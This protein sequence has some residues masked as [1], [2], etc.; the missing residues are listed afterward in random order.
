MLLG[1]LQLGVDD[2]LQGAL[3][4]E[5][6]YCG[7]HVGDGAVAAGAAQAH[8]LS[9]A[10]GRSVRGDASVAL[11]VHRLLCGEDRLDA[12]LAGLLG[13]SFRE[14]VLGAELVAHLGDECIVGHTGDVRDLYLGGIA[15]TTS[16]TAADYWYLALLA[17]V[18]KVGLLAD[19]I[20]GIDNDIEAV[21]KDFLVAAFTVEGLEIVDLAMWVDGFDALL[22][23][24][25]LLV[26]DIAVHRVELAVDIGHA[27]FI[28][29][30]HRDVAHAGAGECLYRPGTNA[31]NADHSHMGLC[32]GL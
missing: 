32:K 24:I 5:E 25:G 3:C 15:Q 17:V 11:R 4:G 12:E 26:A 13:I 22:H 18:E 20:D 2:C 31:A 23:G 10:S 29:I 19:A 6:T 1:F 7:G 21:G 14:A 8:V 30:H 27:D 28:Q 16:S 9:V